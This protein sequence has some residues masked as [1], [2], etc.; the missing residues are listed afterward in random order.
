MVA[1]SERATALGAT[2]GKHFAAILGGHSFTE[3]VLVHTAAVG[4]LK[5][6]FHCIGVLLLISYVYAARRRQAHFGVQNYKRISNPQNFQS[7]KLK[8]TRLRPLRAGQNTSMGMA[9]SGEPSQI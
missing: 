8:I 9:M 3:T 4:G 1:H 5:S 2:A 6:S 7:K